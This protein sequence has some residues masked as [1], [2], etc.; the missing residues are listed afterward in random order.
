MLRRPLLKRLIRL[1]KR[2]TRRGASRQ[3]LLFTVYVLFVV[4][5]ALGVLFLWGRQDM[6][7]ERQ[8][9]SDGNS[10]SVSQKISVD[11]KSLWDVYALVL[12][13]AVPILIAWYNARERIHTDLRAHDD[14]LQAYLDETTNLMGQDKELPDRKQNDVSSTLVRTRTLTLLDRLNLARLERRGLSSD[15]TRKRHIVRFLYEAALVR[16]NPSGLDLESADFSYA[17]FKEL[18]LSEV[19]LSGANLSN[20]DLRGAELSEA[21]LSGANLSNAD[22]RGAELGEANLLGADFEVA[23]VT[24]E[25][26]KGHI[27]AAQALNGATMPDGQQYEK[28]LKSK[29]GRRVVAGYT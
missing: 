19:N 21:N 3:R 12:P 9:Q 10:R 13:L 24:K 1:F 29:E 7:Q 18:E 14:A 5:I 16:G 17:D 8:L 20:A 27:A 11:T 28:W 22:L 2:L 6:Q 23:K 26:I 25:Q 15:A 4:F